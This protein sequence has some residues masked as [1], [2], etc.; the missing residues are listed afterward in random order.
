M[1]SPGTNDNGPDSIQGKEQI[2]W[3]LEVS[4]AFIA[5]GTVGGVAGAMIRCDTS[6]TLKAQKDTGG[7]SGLALTKDG[8]IWTGA[9]VRDLNG[10]ALGKLSDGS[11]A[12]G[13]TAGGSG[14][15]Y[16]AQLRGV[17]QK[18]VKQ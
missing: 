13:V 12:H 2:L 5:N 15:V 10:K 18:F 1:A 8:R 4:L 17:V 6:Q 3:A 11:G 16:L 7:I 9:V 14:D